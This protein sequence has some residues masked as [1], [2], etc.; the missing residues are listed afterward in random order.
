[1]PSCDDCGVV[2]DSM[3][4]LQRHIKTRCPESESLKRKR[5]DDYISEENTSKRPRAEWIKYDNSNDSSEVEDDDIDENEGYEA[6]INE[7]VDSTE[8]IW[9][10][11]YNKYLEK[12]MDE[13]DAMQ[14][15]N[16]KI[17]T[18]VQR[19]YNV[20]VYN[21]FIQRY[22]KLKYIAIAF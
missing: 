15:S 9:D 7:S 13:E 2:L 6:L 10:V 1:M 20:S 3:H 17:T 22:D 11:K 8:K 14:Q 12:G 21:A 18:L 16:Q 5:E 19:P 4:D